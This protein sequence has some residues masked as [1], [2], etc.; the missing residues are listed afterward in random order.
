MNETRKHPI[1]REVAET[2]AARVD[3]QGY[4]FLIEMDEI[5]QLLEIREFVTGMDKKQFNAIQ[6]DCLTKIEG[7]KNELLY[8]HKICLQND[9]KRGY[10][11]LSPDQQVSDA[12]AHYWRQMR[13]KLRKAMDVLVNVENDLLTN[14]GQKNRDRNLSRSVF[15]LRAANKRKIP[16]I[17]VTKKRI[18]Q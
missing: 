14:A 12:F 7:L 4:D 2:I 16:A 9:R 17:E 18:A 8:N 3:E 1:W 15:M 5:K 10:I 6:F 11:V 13:C